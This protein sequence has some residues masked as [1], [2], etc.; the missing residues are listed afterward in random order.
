MAV[1]RGT[2]EFEVTPDGDLIDNAANVDKLRRLWLDRSRINGNDLG[3]GDFGDFDN[4]AWHVAC[5]LLGAGG[6]RQLADGRVAWLEISHKEPD[7]YFASATVLE[8]GGTRTYSIH[9]PEGAQLLAGSK[10]LG[11]VE[12]NST[13][14]ISARG[15]V[16]PPTRFN[17]WMRQDFDK[18]ATSPDDGGKVW[19]HWCTLRNIR[20]VDS[21]TTS[22]IGA[23][24]AL[25]AALGDRFI[26]TV[27]RGRRDY[28]HPRQLAAIVH[29]GL[30]A[31]E[32]ALWHV[33]PTPI[34]GA[35]EALLLQARPS[36][37]LTGVSKLAWGDEPKY[38]MFERRIDR[39]SSSNAVRDDLDS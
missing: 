29:A 30:T 18:A 6:A 16:D 32:S 39:W 25:A 20:Q 3:P 12:G 11:F 4:G 34:P 1:L 37:A 14:R 23:Y 21:F 24:V 10:L 28:A 15:I 38:F 2:S 13:G 35:T 7:A 19:E 17:G 5:H 8:A 22:L 9:T 33:T 26:P 27:A 36:E 31:R